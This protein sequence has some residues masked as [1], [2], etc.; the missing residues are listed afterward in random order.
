[1]VE[2]PDFDRAGAAVVDGP[3]GRLLVLILAG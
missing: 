1:M 2:T 3:T